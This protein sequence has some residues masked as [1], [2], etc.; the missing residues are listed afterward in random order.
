MNSE[1]MKNPLWHLSDSEVQVTTVVLANITCK[2]SKLRDAEQPKN[3][4]K[5]PSITK[6]MQLMV[7]KCIPFIN[8]E[9]PL[10]LALAIAFLR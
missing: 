4:G 9:N 3:V 10:L 7:K 8:T 6:I 1:I 5:S 2:H